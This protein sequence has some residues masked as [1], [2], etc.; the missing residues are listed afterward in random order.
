MGFDA[1]MGFLIVSTPPDTVDYVECSYCGERVFDRTIDS[2]TPVKK[3]VDSFVA[4]L[5]MF[6]PEEIPPNLVT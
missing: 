3:L 4:H 1:A 6:H 5:G 2:V